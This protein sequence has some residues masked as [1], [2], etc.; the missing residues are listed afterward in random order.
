LSRRKTP[1]SDR[2]E[3]HL[4]ERRR[5]PKHQRTRKH[6]VAIDNRFDQHFASGDDIRR[7]DTRQIATH[8]ARGRER[9]RLLCGEH[10]YERQRNHCGSDGDHRLIDPHRLG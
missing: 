6:T 9:E 8:K 3:D 10:T 2:F 4:R 1:S 5:A 7:R